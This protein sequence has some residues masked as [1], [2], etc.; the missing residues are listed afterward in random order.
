MTA[1]NQP[2]YI[3]QPILLDGFLTN[4]SDHSLFVDSATFRD[5]LSLRHLSALSIGL[6]GLSGFTDIVYIAVLG[7]DVGNHGLWFPLVLGP[8][9]IAG[10][11]GVVI[12]SARLIGPLITFPFIYLGTILTAKRVGFRVG[13]LG[14][15]PWIWIRRGEA[16]ERLT[17]HS[18]QLSRTGVL[19]VDTGYQ[20]PSNQDTL[21]A[22]LGTAI[23]PLLNIFVVSP[24]LL[25]SSLIWL[26]GPDHLSFLG[27]FAAMLAAVSLLFAIS[28]GALALRQY[29]LLHQ[30]PV[31]ASSLAAVAQSASLS[32]NG[33]RPR[34]VPSS[35]AQEMASLESDPATSAR[36]RYLI[37]YLLY[38]T[39]FDSGDIEG[40]GS[41]LQS[42]LESIE[43]LSEKERRTFLSTAVAEVYDEAAFFYAHHL[44]DVSAGSGWLHLSNQ[45]A[46]V[47]RHQRLASEAAILYAYGD[48]AA[49]R[50]RAI[51]SVESCHL[52]SI[53][54][55][56]LILDRLQSLIE[57]IDERE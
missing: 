31:N 36:D 57:A 5:R 21:A 20:R 13:V 51:R 54:D 34:D 28:A 47:E 42:A 10:F 8:A 26:R 9:A 4:I 38:L 23:G 39:A 48:L 30:S 43:S 17:H 32:L 46:L 35:L 44:N 3:V 16:L 25:V 14:I 2:R 29:W 1:I 55:N 45:S 50:T 7:S 52:S 37:N 40:A 33:V 41:R 49:A 6:I 15:G 27:V 12:A 53:G 24:V 56:R 11:V 22:Y 19:I 18:N